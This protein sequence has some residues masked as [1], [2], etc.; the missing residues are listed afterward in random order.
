MLQGNVMRLPGSYFIN[1]G[2][3]PARHFTGWIYK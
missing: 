1:A 2:A 3:A